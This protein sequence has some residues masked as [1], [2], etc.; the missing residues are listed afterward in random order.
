MAADG[1]RHRVTRFFFRR[2]KAARE[3]FSKRKPDI[4]T[5]AFFGL[6]YRLQELTSSRRLTRADRLERTLWKALYFQRYGTEPLYA[7]ETDKPIAVESPDH[8]WPRG[9]AF[10]NNTNR[11]FNLKLYAFTGF[12]PD[13][14]VMDLGCSGGGFVKTFLEDGYTAIGL[15]GSDWSKKLRS[16]EWDTCPHHLLTCDITS[17]FQVRDAGGAAMTFH[18]ITAWEVLEHIPT[19]LLPALIENISRHLAPGGIFVCS[20]DTAPDSNPVTGAVYHVTLQPKPWWL[21]QFAKAGLIEVDKHPFTTRDY[22]R[23]HGMGLT[24]WDPADGNG[25]HLVMRKAAQ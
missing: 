12:R 20:V 5:R 11:D 4:F 9:T 14:R 15:E 18:C 24:D 17:R 2:Y 16:A 19:P 1:F 13:L 6:R 23:G 22:V 7:A 25:F 10:D 21:E 8:K 3:F